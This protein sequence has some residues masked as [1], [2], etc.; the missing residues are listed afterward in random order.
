MRLLLAS[1]QL[2]ECVIG[3]CC[4]IEPER[5]TRVGIR[6]E[7]QII[8]PHAFLILRTRKAKDIKKWLN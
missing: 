8:L 5:E 1:H 2:G 6:H 4:T 7:Y 3:R